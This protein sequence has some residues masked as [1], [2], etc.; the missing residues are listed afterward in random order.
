MGAAPS[1]RERFRG[2]LLGL[3]V[4]DALGAPVEFLSADQVVE[5]WGVLTEMV[6]GGCH[7][8]QPGGH[9]G[10]GF[11]PDLRAHGDS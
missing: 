6:G 2:T 10:Q 9:Q 7:G 5:R 4:G 11:R 1:L 8:V 3:A